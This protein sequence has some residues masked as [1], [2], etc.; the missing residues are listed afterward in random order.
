MKKNLWKIGTA[1]LC[2]MTL[3]ASGTVFATLGGSLDPY[4]NNLDVF[5]KSGKEQNLISAPQSL[6]PEG[7]VIALDDQGI[8]IVVDDY[9]LVEQED[10][11]VYVHYVEDQNLPYVIIGYYDMASEGIT[12][13]FTRYMGNNYSDLRVTH[14][15]T[16]EN[17]GGNSYY[18]VGYE[19]TISGYTAQDTRL[20][21]GW[22]G[23][24]YMFGSKEIPSLGYLLPES[25]LEQIAMSFAPLAGGDSDYEKHVDDNRVAVPTTPVDTIG[26]TEGFDG[27]NDNIGG[28]N[29]FSSI[30]GSTGPVG[31]VGTGTT[32][33][34]EVDGSIDFA[35]SMATY[36]GTWVPFD[37]GF[38]LYLPSHWNWYQITDEQAA[39]GMLYLAGDASGNMHAP[40]INVNYAASQG[41]STLD[42]LAADLEAA[43]FTI[44]GKININGIGCVSYNSAAQD[45]AGIMFFHPATTDY[46]FAVV[47]AEFSSNV[48]MQASILCSLT[49]TN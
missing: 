5:G 17:L 25:Y 2:A 48:D 27:N 35:E 24:T 33:G 30:G 23:R 32:T 49:P 4:S 34:N 42:D 36:A 18:K 1:L 29:D 45:L 37:D 22:N 28:S 41:L 9:A 26:G 39:A 47:A 6:V 8:S 15:A 13:A 10:D 44:D 12:D 16:V 38:Q 43:G 20:F 46:V 31:G 3:T 14:T 7:D 11:F 19:Y 40:Y 21:I